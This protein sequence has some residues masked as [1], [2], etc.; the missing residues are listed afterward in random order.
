MFRLFEKTYRW[1]GTGAARGLRVV[2][3]RAVDAAALGCEVIAVHGRPLAAVLPLLDGC[4]SVD[5]PNG[6]APNEPG[7][8]IN[9]RI[10]RGLG[11]ADAAG[12]T[13]T[14][15]RSDL[16][17]WDLTVPEVASADLALID[18]WTGSSATRSLPYKRL[19][20]ARWYEVID[21]TLFVQ[22]NSCDLDAY[23]FFKD[24]VDELGDGRIDRLVV[25][26]RRNSGGN[27][28]PGTWFAKAVAGI[29]SVNR[30]GGIYVLVG[31]RTFSSAMM[32]A[33]DFMRHTE[34]RFAGEPLAERVD[35][36][37]EVKRFGLPASGLV[38][39]HSTKFFTCSRGKDLRTID[40]IVV[41]DPGLE[42]VPTYEEWAA[43]EDPV[44]D[45]A[46]EAA[47]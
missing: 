37:G 2:Q 47:P 5:H 38:V 36:W 23:G 41:P 30:P 26:L 14:L 25:D 12:L 42:R 33:V 28:L 29:R 16:S 4:L 20:D 35:M 32:M 45:L 31:P 7:A 24:I 15:R 9:P 27:S 3:A 43:G 39:G 44:F 8:L 11:L 34:A 13:V 46:V 22:Y 21:G 19:G 18:V 17:T 40:G 6:L 10:A 1:F